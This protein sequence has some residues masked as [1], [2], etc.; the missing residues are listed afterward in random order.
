MKN[1]PI[2]KMQRC[3]QRG[4]SLIEMMVALVLSLV[5]VVGVGQIYLG[6]KQTYRMQDGQSRLQENLR[7][8]MEVLARD[9]RSAGYMGCQSSCAVMVP[10]S[11]VCRSSSGVFYDRIGNCC[12]VVPRSLLVNSDDY[13]SLPGVLPTATD[14]AG[15]IIRPSLM[16]TGGDDIVSGTIATGTS[17]PAV[18]SEL[19]HVVQGLDPI[20]AAVTGTDAITVMF[21]ESCNGI[22]GADTNSV[23]PAVASLPSGNQCDGGTAGTPLVIADCAKAHVFRADPSAADATLN[24]Q[25]LFSDSSD[26]KRNSEIMVFRSYTYYIRYNVAGEPALY[27]LDNTK[28]AVGD[29]PREVIDGIENMQI[30]YGVDSDNDSSANQYVAATGVTDWAQVVSVRI[31]LTAHS[32]GF[33]GDSLS[34]TPHTYPFND[35]GTT[36]TARPLWKSLTAT[37]SVRNRMR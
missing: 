10:S 12:Q 36:K 32:V 5:L 37:I 22:T 19:S 23:N 29:N 1:M 25:A 17:A 35:V 4:V 27:Q 24:T 13:P 31:T 2:V 15:A 30:E 33:N 21:G 18:S 20:S 34:D 3:F 26:Y 9:I 16:I 8:A 11:G 7:Y 28:K 14:P 6:S